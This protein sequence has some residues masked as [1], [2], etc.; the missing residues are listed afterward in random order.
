MRVIRYLNNLPLPGPL[1]PLECRA[2]ATIQLLR[3]LEGRMSAAAHGET[4]I[5]M[6]A[7]L[8]RPLR[9]V[10]M[11]SPPQGALHGKERI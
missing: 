7:R 5:P 10:K 8:R 1:P 4:D 9:S 3:G 6:P 11:V 2:R